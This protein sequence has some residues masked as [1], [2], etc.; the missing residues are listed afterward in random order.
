MN[1]LKSTWMLLGLCTWPA[2]RGTVP[3]D[4]LLPK[5]AAPEG[6]DHRGVRSFFGSSTIAAKNRI[7][8]SGFEFA[9]AWGARVVNN[10]V[11]GVASTL[12][13]V[14]VTEAADWPP[15]HRGF[16]KPPARHLPLGCLRAQRRLLGVLLP[17]CHRFDSRRLHLLRPRFSKPSLPRRGGR[18]P[19]PAHRAAEALLR[20]GEHVLREPLAEAHQ[21]A[22]RDVEV[23]LRFRLR[24]LE[25]QQP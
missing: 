15:R 17:P 1:C 25:R 6:R 18:G 3:W 20:A 9:P 19:L 5:P 16:A 14:A 13:P 22:H 7:P 23:Q 11:D 21:E 2:K 8:S 10:V 12:V 4:T 24:H